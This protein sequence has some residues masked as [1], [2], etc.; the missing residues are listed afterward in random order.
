[1]SEL[2]HPFELVAKAIG[3]S[4]EIL[5]ESSEMYRDFGW[6]SFGHLNVILALESEYGI[7]V[8]DVSIESYKTMREILK[9]YEIVCL[10]MQS[11]E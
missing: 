9:C 1:M 8:D 2:I 5:S 11:G 6:D 7:Q 10:R 3:C 4:P